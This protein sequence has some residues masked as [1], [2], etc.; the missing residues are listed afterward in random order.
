MQRSISDL[1]DFLV[2]A[3]D[4]TGLTPVLLTDSSLVLRREFYESLMRHLV[5]AG[6]RSLRCEVL[7]IDTW[8]PRLL[9]D[10]SANRLRRQ[11][12]SSIPSDLRELVSV[13]QRLMLSRPSGPLRPLTVG[14]V[15]PMPLNHVLSRLSSM[16]PAWSTHVHLTA[17]PTASDQ[18]QL[19]AA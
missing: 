13:E 7:A 3:A 2:E 8:R 17:R 15:C 1:A 16:L 18:I 19:A 12:Q 11:L 6:E 5:Q 9:D 4:R 10:W 14:F